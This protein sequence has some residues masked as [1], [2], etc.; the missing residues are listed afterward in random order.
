[1]SNAVQTLLD[2]FVEEAQP[3]AERLTE[4]LLEV[5]RRWSA[6]LSADQILPQIKSDLH[7]LKGNSG[8][9]G[10]TPIQSLT[11]AM[12][13]VCGVLSEQPVLQSPD[14]A[15]LLVEASDAVVETIHLSTLGPLEPEQTKSLLD[16]LRECGL[17]NPVLDRGVLSSRQAARQQPGGLRGLIR[18]VVGRSARKSS[19]AE[20]AR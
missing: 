10:F 4:S 16:Q 2:D 20:D 19:P 5:E 7:T 9:M 14:T 11:H 15:D 13:D 8:M 12:E 3:L 6:G 1:M 18:R 17:C